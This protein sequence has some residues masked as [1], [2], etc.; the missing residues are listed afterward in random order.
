M[1]RLTLMFYTT[2][3]KKLFFP[4]VNK[5][6]PSSKAIFIAIS[7]PIGLH[8]INTYSIALNAPYLMT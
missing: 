8:K 1:Y 4:P 2:R 5:I 3:F 6:F 7:R